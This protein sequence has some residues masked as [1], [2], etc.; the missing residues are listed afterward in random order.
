MIFSGVLD[1]D[2]YQY[3]WVKTH[4]LWCLLCFTSAV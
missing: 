3:P 1:I 2:C 4:L